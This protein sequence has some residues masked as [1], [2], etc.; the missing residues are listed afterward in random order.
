MLPNKLANSL[1]ISIRAKELLIA[2]VDFLLGRVNSPPE[3][4]QLLGIACLT[5]VVKVV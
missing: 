2:L 5:M 1:E 4:L 3:K